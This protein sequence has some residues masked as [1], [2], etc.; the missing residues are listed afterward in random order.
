MHQFT[1]NFLEPSQ[2]IYENEMRVSTSF[3]NAQMSTFREE[4]SNRQ[5][6]P[7][8][9]HATIKIHNSKIEDGTI[10]IQNNKLT[11]PME[12]LSLSHRT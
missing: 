7:T 5:S 4:G 10:F 1:K 8:I 12:T 3:Q 2:K 9:F 6:Q 11:C